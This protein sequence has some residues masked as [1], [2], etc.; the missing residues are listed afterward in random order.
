[1]GAVEMAK[2]PR[3]WLLVGVAGF[4][5]ISACSQGQRRSAAGRSGPGTVEAVSPGGSSPERPAMALGVPA[6]SSS[7]KAQEALIQLVQQYG[8]YYATSGVVNTVDGPIAV[9]AH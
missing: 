8:T 3:S 5:L 4:I 6:A 9:V 2:R 7:G 1:M